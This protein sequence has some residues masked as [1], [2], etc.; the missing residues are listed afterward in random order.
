MALLLVHG[1]GLSSHRDT[2]FGRDA[3]FDLTGDE[4]DGINH[5]RYYFHPR[6][7]HC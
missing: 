4:Y 6:H 3:D 7:P 1:P 5:R 2:L